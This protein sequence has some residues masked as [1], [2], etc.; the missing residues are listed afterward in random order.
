[1][2]VNSG[3][4]VTN[5]VI[6]GR[7]LVLIIKRT[8]P[9]SHFHPPTPILRWYGEDEPPGFSMSENCSW[10]PN[11]SIFVRGRTSCGQ[12]KGFS[13]DDNGP[14]HPRYLLQ[15]N[16]QD[17]TPFS[18]PFFML[19]WI[20]ACFQERSRVINVQALRGARAPFFYFYLFSQWVGV[21]SRHRY[22][23]LAFFNDRLILKRFWVFSV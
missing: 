9:Y 20:S 14:S 17:P 7:T 3:R 1:M 18:H 16:F 5:D 6:Y 21:G 4:R 13:G 10:G 19:W 8:G 15:G 12:T 11:L 22:Y 23:H 2:C